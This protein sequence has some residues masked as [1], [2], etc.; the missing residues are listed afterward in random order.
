VTTTVA[1][2]RV[3]TSR[4]HD[5]P[6]RDAPVRGAAALNAAATAASLI[7]RR[8]RWPL[9]TISRFGRRDVGAKDSHGGVH[10]SMFEGVC[11]P[12]VVLG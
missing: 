10:Q 12:T 11:W 8:L 7:A 4:C 6:A 5:G 1:F 3:A 9:P 2:V